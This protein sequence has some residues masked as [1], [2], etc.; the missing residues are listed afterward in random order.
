LSLINVTINGA[1]NLVVGGVPAAYPM[2]R[3]RLGLTNQDIA[4]VLSFVR[5]GWN[6]RAPEIKAQDVAKVRASTSGK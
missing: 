3:F 6:N 1:A 2:P 4:D 5:S